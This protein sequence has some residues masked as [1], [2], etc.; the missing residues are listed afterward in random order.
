MSIRFLLTALW[1]CCATPTSFAQANP[2]VIVDGSAAKIFL[3]TNTQFRSDPE[4]WQP[5]DR[6]S[7][8]FGMTTNTY[9]LKHE[10]QVV[11]KGSQG[12]GVWFY[13]LDNG[14]INEA[15][16]IHFIDNKEVNRT[17]MGTTVPFTEREI[18]Y[19]NFTFPVQ[20]R[21]G[22]HQILVR[23]KS[24]TNITVTPI[25][26]DPFDWL[27]DTSSDQIVLGAF[28]GVLIILAIYNLCVF[29]V[30]R[31]RVFLVFTI[32]ILAALC[33]RLSQ[34]GI[35]SQF[36]Y[37]ADPEWHGPFVR[38]AGATM[39]ASILWFT[40]E[41]LRTWEWSQLADRWLIIQASIMLSFS[42]L[43][44]FDYLPSLSMLFFVCS[45]FV[46]LVVSAIAVRRRVRGSVPFLFAMSFYIGGILL[47]IGHAIGA[48]ESAAIA[49]WGND[50]SLIA[51]GVVS[52]VGLASRLSEEKVSKE[53]A[54]NE[55]HAKSEFLANMSHEIRTPLNAI[56]GFT[57]LL[58]E[59]ELGKDQRDY[60]K[61]VQTAS[62]SLSG[63][64][65]DVLDYSKIEAGKLV[66]ENQPMSVTSIF[67][68]MES[69]FSERAVENDT[70][71]TLHIAEDVPKQ[72]KGDSLRVAQILT[73][74]ISNALKFT[75][76]GTVDVSAKVVTQGESE[77]RI[78]FEVKDTG[79]GMTPDQQA[80]LFS[81]FTQADA[82][83][84][85]KFGGTGLG[86]AICKQLSELMGGSIALES[87][88]GKGSTFTVELPFH[89]NLFDERMPTASKLISDLT[90][91][92]ALLV[93][94]NTTNQLLAKTM[95]RKAGA[96]CDVA[97]N[98]QEA[99]DRLAT[100][101]Y[102]VVLM[103]CQMPVMDGYE[104]T[105]HIRKTLRMTKL[106]IIAM[107]ANALQGDRERCLD[108]GMDDYITK[109][110]KIA[111]LSLIVKKWVN[112]SKVPTSDALPA[113]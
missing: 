50:L 48:I 27:F 75:N 12:P 8:N 52:S 73:N 83:T 82:S 66:L 69:M 20:I 16:F 54:E 51:L 9:W 107:T 23:L 104:T 62:K 96:D 74:L 85:R 59:M 6:R 56:V 108:A 88:S 10:F 93:E 46:C 61:R 77:T 100:T 45:P 76:N 1:L 105:G 5:N 55:A 34:S 2:D 30:V 95:L 63:I 99:L 53:L 22:F 7:L 35:A 71:L 80:V 37:P 33:W 106:P 13:H 24:E 79:I 18:T 38:I 14:N 87:T 4:E 28:F 47:G 92:R 97:A 98:G 91:V 43:P 26:Q 21:P 112:M 81:P 36:I 31:E 17:T 58:R 67:N 40:R 84:T 3:G 57:E 65:N 86:L 25:L 11:P 102:D 64:I 15:E 41:F 49:A 109:P 42:I 29:A 19:R 89:R 68:N 101:A 113:T 39:V 94:D 103:D 110:I 111:D 78:R 44:I 90:G 70:Q 60:V 32:T 72:I